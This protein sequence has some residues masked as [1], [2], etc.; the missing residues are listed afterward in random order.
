ML[1]LI[2]APGAELI[3]L[4]LD[5]AALEENLQAGKAA[6][7][8]RA[9]A[10]DGQA[11]FAWCE[12]RGLDPLAATPDTIA[13]HLSAAAEPKELPSGELADGLSAG[14][15]SRRVAGIAYA[16]QLLGVPDEALPT[17]HKLVRETLAGIRRRYLRESSQ[18]SPA[19]TEI[20]RAM[21]DACDKP[22]VDAKGKPPLLDKRNVLGIR[23]RALLA[24]G[25][26]GAFRRSELV[27]LN[28][29]DLTEVEQGL[30]VSIRRSK[31]NQSGPPEVIPIG[32]GSRLR[33]IEALRAW[34]QA[35]QI[36]EGAIFRRVHKAGGVQPE[37]LTPAMVAL[38]V[39]RRAHLAGFTKA[40]VEKLSGHSL[41]AGFI[42]SAAVH[43]ANVFKIM[44]VSRHKSMDVMKG[45]VR[46]RELFVDYAGDGIL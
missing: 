33:P 17:R 21:L 27:A 15:L 10:A 24:F 44:S 30:H 14:S 31:T 36:Q 34:L 23:D 37:R 42:T 22:G 11:F 7:T 9:Y 39:K 2:P 35:A 40:E 32:F 18:K 46:D 19:T 3:A 8:R 6:S 43:G 28:V 45:Y 12:A 16:L 25:F 20:I 4:D 5:R 29:A 13:L 1:D 38:I 26:A 41:R